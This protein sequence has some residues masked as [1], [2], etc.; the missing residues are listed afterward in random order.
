MR[1]PCYDCCL[2]HLSKAAVISSETALG[3]PE[4]C[5]YI[6]GNLSEAEDEIQGFS[7]EMASAIREVRLKYMADLSY[8]FVP[9]V[10]TLFVE[11]MALKTIAAKTE[12]K[13][14]EESPLP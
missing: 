10:E 2:K 14:A 3:Y 9:E 13:K 4:H 7:L 8:N 12:A 6:I 5:M 11:V 1:K